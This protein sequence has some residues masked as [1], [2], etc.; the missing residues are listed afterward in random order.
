MNSPLMVA[1]LRA[2]NSEDSCPYVS[3]LREVLLG[4]TA[5][6]LGP[7][8]ELLQPAELREYLLD[9]R[10]PASQFGA[11]VDL[12]FLKAA[13]RVLFVVIDSRAAAQDTL[14]PSASVAS[15]VLKHIDRME[16]PPNTCILEVLLKEPGSLYESSRSDPR[17]ISF[18]LTDLDERDLRLSFLT[19]YA[20]HNAV[21]LLTSGPGAILAKA[22]KLFFSHAKR[23]GVPLTTAAGDWLKRVKGFEKY[24]DTQDLDLSGDL[25]AQLATAVASA[26]VVVFRSDSFDDRYWCQKEILWAEQNARPV[27][28]VDARWQI[29][30]APS[31]VSFDSMP[32]VRIPD[33]SVVRIFTA[34]LIESLRVELFKLRVQGYASEL[35]SPVFAVIPR[36]PSVLAL[37]SACAALKTTDASGSHSLIVYP[38]PALPQMLSD[39]ANDLADASVPGCGVVS[40]DEFRL[41]L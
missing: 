1:L 3:R 4:L 41:R 11:L 21:R 19:L 13:D 24:Y 12:N 10:D 20:L 14:V 34:A 33:G 16:G 9:S 32:G 27:I 23:D 25:T 17:L 30:S 2:G 15:A 29:E 22:P 38:N 37:A 40:L 39:A 35:S 28:I 36:S 8:R 26:I 31:V 6:G 7:S 18:G 5:N